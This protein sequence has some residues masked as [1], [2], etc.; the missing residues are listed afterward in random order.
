MNRI[1]RVVML[2][3]LAA[4]LLAGCVRTSQPALKSTAEWPV[5]PATRPTTPQLSS[6]QAT[7]RS[8]LAWTSFAYRSGVSEDASPTMSADEG[9]RIDSYIELNKERGRTIDQQLLVIRFGPTSTDGSRTIVPAHEQWRYR[10]L[11]PDGSQALSP[12]YAISYDT[13]YTLVSRGGHL[14]VDRVDAKPL[15][16][17]K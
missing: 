6:P 2:G 13:T 17:V 4:L 7:V 1:H 11:N 10:Y 12:V 9:V 16:A 14:V 3:V 5:A 8:Y 15:G